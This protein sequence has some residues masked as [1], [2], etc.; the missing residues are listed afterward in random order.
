MNRPKPENQAIDL[1]KQPNDV[2][3]E[4]KMAAT[5]D[6]LQLQTHRLRILNG[7]A[8]AIASDLDLESIVQT[9]TD[10][11]TDLSGAKFGAFFYNTTDASGE[12]YV[13]YTLSGVPREAFDRFGLPRN[14]AVFA[15][16]FDGTSIVRSDDIRQDPRY[17][18]NAP[19]FGMPKGHLP[20]VSYMAVPVISRSGKVHG[21][22]FFGHDI[23]GMFTEESEELVVAIAAHA[24][25]AIDNAR[26]L[27]SYQTELT[28]HQ[29][30]HET[31]ARLAAIVESSNDAILSK[32]LNGVILSWNKGA[33]RLFGYTEAE[34]IGQPVTVLIP[35]GRDDEEP[36][37]LARI[38][39][40]ERIDHYETVRR[41]KDGS[42][43]DISLSVSPIRNA[44][45]VVI[46]A[47]KIA[48]DITER[49]LVQEQQA[50]MMHEMSHR[51]KNLLTLATSVAVLSARSAETPAALVAAIS[52]R[53]SA[54]SRA[55][56]LILPQW[57]AE[58]AI[59]QAS[60][61]LMTLAKAILA[62]YAD[63]AGERIVIRGKDVEIGGRSLTSIAL[64][65]HE[66][67]TNAAKY[68]ALSVPEG[69][70]S[71]DVSI[72]QDELTLVWTERHGPKVAAAP[73][74]SGF[75]S[76]LERGVQAQL[77][78]RIAR[79]WHRDG[80]V[81]RMSLPVDKLT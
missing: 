34:I 61:N 65:L 46:G 53:L 27:C 44:E 35:A 58:G 22:L 52:E 20:V 54:L 55:H 57:S 69:R 6:A 72:E 56:E 45:G 13:L 31:A 39:R 38:R 64:L 59:T 11:A 62:P 9:V 43:I 26:L 32:N 21:G 37:I 48:H 2:S 50:L 14:T 17:G 70:V 81:I 33:E 19:H 18:Q 77:Q 25:V 49:R 12:S 41:R 30:L 47:A 1:V 68:G 36:S 51:I 42:L 60:V 4:D 74:T 63:A 40:G 10:A 7:V 3:G 71:I 28:S 73:T 66:F 16:T 67:A 80:L 15:P 75:G 76:R 24:A 8:K 79:D 5:V 78:C 29:S 23:P